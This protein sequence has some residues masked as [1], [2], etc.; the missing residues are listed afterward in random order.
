MSYSKISFWR[1]FSPKCGFGA[2][3]HES[4]GHYTCGTHL[5]TIIPNGDIARCVFFEADPMGNIKKGLAVA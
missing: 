1:H 5:A 4:T 3:A 2:G